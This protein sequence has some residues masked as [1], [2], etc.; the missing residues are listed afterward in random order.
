MYTDNGRNI[1]TVTDLRLAEE[2]FQ[3]IQTTLDNL[4]HLLFGG[5]PPPSPAAMELNDQT[6]ASLF[7]PRSNDPGIL[8]QSTPQPPSLLSPFRDP[9]RS[10]RSG[11]GSIPRRSNI[12]SPQTSIPKSS[13]LPLPQSV[14][15]SLR[16]PVLP[17]QI[18][19][20]TAPKQPSLPTH[21]SQTKIGKPSIKKGPNKEKFSLKWESR[22]KNRMVIR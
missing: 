18:S 14:R 16:S 17:S 20:H 6:F 15:P 9:I 2:Y 19:Q 1:L 7:G 22:V 21:A 4:H 8:G 3:Q 11:P 5:H 13:R 10:S 12:R